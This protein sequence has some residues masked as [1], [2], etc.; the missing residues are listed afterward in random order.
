MDR[1]RQRNSPN[2]A[3]QELAPADMLNPR[4]ISHCFGAIAGIGLCAA[5]TARLRLH[6]VW[7]DYLDEKPDRQS[8][9]NPA[10]G[11]DII[12]VV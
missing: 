12:A 8:E 2:P 7:R 9:M 1:A 5:K 3:R 10:H 4:P 11:I 6:G